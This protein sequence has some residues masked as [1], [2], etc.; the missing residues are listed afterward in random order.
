MR[1]GDVILPLQSR[2]G[3][4][5]DQRAAVRSIFFPNAGTGVTWVKTMEIPIWCARKE[6]LSQ[7]KLRRTY[8][9]RK[10]IASPKYISYHHCDVL[11]PTQ[12]STSIVHAF[13]HIKFLRI[14]FHLLTLVSLLNP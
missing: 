8:L 9:V 13:F 4:T 10:K 2:H 1:H 12:L 6:F 3:L 7:G 5:C 11:S 14:I